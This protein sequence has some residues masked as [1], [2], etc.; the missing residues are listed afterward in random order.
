MDPDLST[1]Y[2]GIE[3][4]N[5]LILSPAGVSETV[6]RMKKAEEAG[7]GAVVVKTLFEDRVTRR[8]PTPRFRL[9]RGRPDCPK[10]FVLYS[11]EQASAFGPQRYSQEIARAKRVL[12]IPVIAS[13]GC[14]TN[15]AWLGYC[16]M[17]QEAGADGIE[18]NLSC[19]HSRETLSEAD[20]TRPMCEVTRLVK[21]A[22]SIPVIPK[23]TPQTASPTR[24]AT[25]LQRSGADAIVMFNRFTGLDIDPGTEA[26]I[27]HGGFAGHGG[28]WSI[29]Y[30]LRWLVA[31]SPRLRIPISASG[32][33]WTGTDMF[34]AILAGATTT[35]MCTAV[36]VRGY[37]A[38]TETLREIKALMTEK[39]YSSVSDFRGKA[40]L[41]VLSTDQIDRRRKVLAKINR[42]LC[43][44]CALCERVCVYDAVRKD[45]D[46][47]AVAGSCVGC[48]LCSQI[49]PERAISLVPTRRGSIA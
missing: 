44:A 21:S 5:P 35:Q 27:M 10:S 3:L 23:M 48:G 9:I 14:T 38:L 22:V 19:P 13:V 39:S 28:P 2:A 30:V 32:G 25:R 6:K 47:F 12:S 15:D 43:T 8:S 1:D 4:A 18:L 26:P 17:V 31:A 45:G 36:V 37:S 46:V 16:R 24:L 11:Y 49:C 41:R 40:C 33:I 42:D 34:K 29:H 7:C 20:L